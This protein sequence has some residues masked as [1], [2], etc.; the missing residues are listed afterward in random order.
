MA[1]PKVERMV[2]MKVG[3][4]VV[5][6]DVPLA[7]GWAVMMAKVSV[8]RLAVPS[9]GRMVGWLAELWVG[10]MVDCWVG[11]LVLRMAVVLVDYSAVRW[12]DSMAWKSAERKDYVTAVMKA[13]PAAACWAA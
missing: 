10:L 3:W 5:Q 7:D 6:K 11:K 8:D 2:A 4:R 13:V 9:G 12:V 1:L